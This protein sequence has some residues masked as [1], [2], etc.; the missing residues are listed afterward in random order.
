MHTQ[1]LDNLSAFTYA[2]SALHTTSD[3]RYM[4]A[5]VF[6]RFTVR[7]CERARALTRRVGEDGEKGGE[8]WQLSLAKRKTNKL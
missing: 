6:V 2:A 5:R 1:T 8:K 4:R 3:V 7:V